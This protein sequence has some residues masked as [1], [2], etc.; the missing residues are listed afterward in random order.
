MRELRT[1]PCLGLMAVG[2]YT[3]HRVPLPSDDLSGCCAMSDVCHG[4]VLL[5][6][7]MV[8]IELPERAFV[9]IIPDVCSSRAH[10]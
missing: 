6:T 8:A 5:T 10:K 9:Q 3:Q 1:S 2:R 7:V 4:I